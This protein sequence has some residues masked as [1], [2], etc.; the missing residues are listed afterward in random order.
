M[1]WVCDPYHGGRL[2]IPRIDAIYRAAY[3]VRRSFTALGAAFAASRA[4]ATDETAPLAKTK[5]RIASTISD[6]SKRVGQFSKPFRVC[7]LRQHRYIVECRAE[8]SAAGLWRRRMQRCGPDRNSR[9]IRISGLESTQ[10]ARR[11][12]VEIATLSRLRACYRWC[13]ISES[14]FGRP[15]PGC[16]RA[17]IFG[18][19]PQRI[20]LS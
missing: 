8:R 19:E 14:P 3:I 12:R 15:E 6:I 11:F 1:T 9:A 16:R 5:W 7:G 13:H 2:K 18:I 20:A 4:G 10:L 17:G